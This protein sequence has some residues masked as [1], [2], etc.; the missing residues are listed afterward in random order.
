MTREEKRW[1]I[2]CY[3]DKFPQTPWLRAAQICYLTFCSL[4]V[5]HGLPGPR[6]RSW[7]AALLS[8]AGEEFTP[9]FL[10]RLHSLA[11]GPF[12]H[13]QC[14]QRRICGAH[15]CPHVFFSIPLA[16]FRTLEV[17]SSPAG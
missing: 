11:Q 6:S 7:P 10:R 8:R 9:L 3:C 16:V 14:Q 1:C 5:C 12:L 2:R 4:E 17:T 15:L 13:L